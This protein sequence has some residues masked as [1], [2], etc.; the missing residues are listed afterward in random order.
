MLEPFVIGCFSRDRKKQFTFPSWI[1]W[2][3]IVIV[4]FLGVTW[5]LCG[6]TVVAFFG[7]SWDPSKWT[8]M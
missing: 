1:G 3:L 6:D 7:G 5:W 2:E 8:L 4:V